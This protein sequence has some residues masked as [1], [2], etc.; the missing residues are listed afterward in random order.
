MLM[1]IVTAGAEIAGRVV[2]GDGL[3]TRMR[4]KT[5]FTIR[6]ESLERFTDDFEQLINFFIIEFQRVVFVENIWVTGGVSYYHAQISQAARTLLTRPQAFVASFLSYYLVKFVPLWGLFLITDSILFLAPLIYLSNQEFIDEHLR[7]AGNRI[8]EQTAQLKDM[9]AQHT[10][11]ATEN[12]RQSASEYTHKFQELVGTA[13]H[14]VRQKTGGA[15]LVKSS[16]FPSAPQ[17][18]PATSAPQIKSAPE[19]VHENQHEHEPEGE[20]AL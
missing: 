18:E 4:P 14:R 16:D 15:P 20:P 10:G 1:E 9:A 13:Q 2:L 7:N 6:K 12:M 19:P 3:A 17:D 5:Y 11:R 8:N